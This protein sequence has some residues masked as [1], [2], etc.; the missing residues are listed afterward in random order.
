MRFKVG[1]FAYLALTHDWILVQFAYELALD[2]FSGDGFK[3][4]TDGKKDYLRQK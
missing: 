4:Q 3:L 2:Q 1:A